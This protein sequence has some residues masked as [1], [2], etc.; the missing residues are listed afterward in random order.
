LFS[1]RVKQKLYL[2]DNSGVEPFRALHYGVLFPV[3]TTFLSNSVKHGSY[4]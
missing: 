1:V 2:D 4:H 3:G